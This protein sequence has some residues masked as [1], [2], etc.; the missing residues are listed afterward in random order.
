M[1]SFAR[2]YLGVVAGLMGWLLIASG[3]VQTVPRGA[4]SAVPAVAQLVASGPAEGERVHAGSSALDEDDSLLSEES[5]EAGG[6]GDDGEQPPWRGGGVHWSRF[7]TC[8]SLEHEH[9]A[10]RGFDDGAPRV[11]H[12]RALGARGPPTLA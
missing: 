8:L 2:K 9:N 6:D 12:P 1:I 11:W 3:V 10:L 5:E 4:I 7:A